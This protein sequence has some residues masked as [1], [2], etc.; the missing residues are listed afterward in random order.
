MALICLTVSPHAPQVQTLPS[1][2]TRISGSQACTR[3]N[4]RLLYGNRGPV[5]LNERFDPVDIGAIPASAIF[6]E[7]TTTVLRMKGPFGYIGGKNRIADEIIRIFPKHTTY[8][9]AF[10]GGAQVLF[11]KQPSHIEVLNDLDH[12]VVIFFRVCQSHYEELTRYTKFLLPS[13]QWF[14]LL[15]AQDPKAL[16]DIQ[17]AARFLYLRKNAYA[18]TVRTQGFRYAVEQGPI[19]N[20]KSLP[21]IIERT[22][23]RLAKVQIEC[24]PYDEVLRRYDRTTTLFYLDPPYWGRKLYRFNFSTSD[25]EELERRLE[26]VRGAF[27][28]SLN[29]VPEVRKLFSKFHLS[30]IELSYTAQ[31][32]PKKRFPELLITNYKPRE[33]QP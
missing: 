28:L 26:K 23:D 31:R 4:I 1:R 20:P 9:E 30:E 32:D 7:L 14:E 21:E 29:D 2:C 19:F 13:R 10:A 24:A 27:V 12:E 3:R 18:G 16:T 25:F 33:V 22:H 8:V 15:K 6:H 17:R 11:H 5:N